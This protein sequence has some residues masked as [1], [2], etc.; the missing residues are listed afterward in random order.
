MDFEISKPGEL[1]FIRNSSNFGEM[2]T[3]VRR[4]NEKPE[5]RA[6]PFR[7]TDS[8]SLSVAGVGLEPDLENLG[9]K[10]CGQ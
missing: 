8:G 2:S 10:E 3:A 4:A 7:A 6:A 1:R 9:Q 5:P